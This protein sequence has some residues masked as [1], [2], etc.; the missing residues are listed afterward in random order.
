M[1]RRQ[2]DARAR[3]VLRNMEPGDFPALVDLSRRVYG[4]GYT[5]Q[6]LRGQLSHFPEGQF[7]AE[8]D[9]RVVGHCAT[10]RIDESLAM[11]PHTW[12]EITGGGFASRHDPKGNWLYGMEVCVDPEFRGVRIGRRLY[13][14]RKRLCEA[15]DLRGIVFVGRLPGLAR[16]LRQFG[17]VE[18]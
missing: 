3:L 9:G 14:C 7:V 12:R 5:P 18:D 8:Y 2:S 10:F 17:S 4:N 13:D 6:M 16:K 15:L 11:A 1:P